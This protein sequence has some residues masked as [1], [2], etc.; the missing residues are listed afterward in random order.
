MSDT[1]TLHHPGAGAEA[2]LSPTHRAIVAAAEHPLQ[3]SGD[4]DAYA[5]L[6]TRL[7]CDTRR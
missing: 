6:L 3:G 1:D 4:L 5:R 2:R 7:V